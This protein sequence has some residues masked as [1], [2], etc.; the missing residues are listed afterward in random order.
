MAG[1]TVFVMATMWLDVVKDFAALVAIVLA[2]ALRFLAMWRGWSS[3][4]PRDYTE[5]VTRLPKRI[6]EMIEIPAPPAVQ[7]EPETRPTKSN[8]IDPFM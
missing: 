8:S 1:S 3:P 6:L 7:E 2:V 5:H 4:V